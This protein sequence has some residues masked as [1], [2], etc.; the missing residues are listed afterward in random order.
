[1][2][3]DTQFYAVAIPAA[4]IAG[5]AKGGF[6]GSAAF[7]ATALLALI[8]PPVVA[9]GIMLPLLMLVDF[10]VLKPFWRKWHWPSAW[11][12]MVGAMPGIALGVLLFRVANPDV[13]RILIG[14]VSLAFVAFQMAQNRGLVSQPERPFDTKI[15]LLAGLA[16]GFI[17]FVSHAGGPLTA[18]YLLSLGLKKTTYQATTVL[19]WWVINVARAVPYAFLGVFTYDTLRADLIMAPAALIGAAAGVYAHKLMP[20][21]WFFAVTYV[22]LLGAGGK[23]ILDGVS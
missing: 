7:V 20:E 19:V 8:I 3:F 5:F 14:L 15:G 21:R 6:G 12:L 22:L 2:E 11:A 9:L 16:S 4:F 1:M 18:I 23:L 13:L 17:T 10:A